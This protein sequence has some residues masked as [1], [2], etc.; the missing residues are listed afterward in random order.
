[1]ELKEIFGS[2]FV[3]LG[4][5]ELEQAEG[6][7]HELG[8]VLPDYASFEASLQTI[9]QEVGFEHVL[10]WERSN[11]TNT[12]R[13]GDITQYWMK[14]VEDYPND[15]SSNFFTSAGLYM[16]VNEDANAYDIYEKVRKNQDLNPKGSL[17]A[18]LNWVPNGGWT[19]MFS[20]E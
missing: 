8:Q 15:L 7:F 12:P 19:A 1:M 16:D 20:A 6:C 4:G 17:S 9:V 2:Q 13:V 3:H 14:D 11:R 5:D 18:H 10:R